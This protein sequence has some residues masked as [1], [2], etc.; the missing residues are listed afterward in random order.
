MPQGTRQDI[1]DFLSQKKL[2]MVGVSRNPKEYSRSL[3]KDFRDRGFEV[4]PVN[5]KLQEV[6]GVT[7]YASIKDV[8]GE[9]DGVIV[10]TSAAASETVVKEVNELGIHRVWIP[11][12]GSDA[13]IS[14]NAVKYCNDNQMTVIA[15]YCPYMF[16]KDAQFFHRL[17]GG[18][19]NLIGKGPK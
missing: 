5:P 17:H 14:K 8:P 15:G 10:L 19:L 2:V 13:T 1:D 6:D 12:P 11:G 18:L 9:I 7:C 4:V 16:I 3:F